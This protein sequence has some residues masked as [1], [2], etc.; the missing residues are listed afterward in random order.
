LHT[1]HNLFAQLEME[2]PT[3]TFVSSDGVKFTVSRRAV[4][5]SKTVSDMLGDIGKTSDPIPCP[6]VHSEQLRKIIFFMEEHANHTDPTGEALEDWMRTRKPSDFPDL[7]AYDNPNYMATSPDD[8]KALLKAE[9]ALDI[10]MCMNVLLKQLSTETGLPE[11]AAACH[12]MTDSEIEAAVIKCMATYMHSTEPFT[13][14]EKAA[15]DAEYPWLAELKRKD[16]DRD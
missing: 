2:E 4:E 13:A 12:T 11:V 6:T 14:E 7:H 15:V 9:S 10:P 3:E 1:S 8:W 5:K 16:K